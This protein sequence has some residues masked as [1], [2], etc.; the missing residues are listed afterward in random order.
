[1]I[2]IEEQRIA[3]KLVEQYRTGFDDFLS[4]N[5]RR[6][7]K[8]CQA[9]EEKKREITAAIVDGYGWDL[10]TIRKSVFYP[11]PQYPEIAVTIDN[12]T[13]IPRTSGCYFAWEFGRVRYVGRAVDLNRRLTKSHH[14]IESHWRLSWI[15]LPIK[16]LYFAE[17]FYIGILRPFKNV[18]KPTIP[19]R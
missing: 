18:A 12:R 4:S 13:A 1:M 14:A 8:E 9:L 11:K 10:G 17:A 19:S 5:L 15:E 7:K 6:L 2:T 3:E 16:E